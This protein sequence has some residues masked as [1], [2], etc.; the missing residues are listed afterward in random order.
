[1]SR[2][3]VAL[4]VS[5]LCRIPAVVL[6]DEEVTTRRICK[7][8]GSTRSWD[9]DAGITVLNDGFL[10][11]L[12]ADLGPMTLYQGKLWFILGDTWIAGQPWD[13][14]L[15]PYTVDTAPADGITIEGYLNC[16]AFPA[17]ALS[18]RPNYPI[19]NALFTVNGATS[20][21]M[22]AQFMDVYEVDGHDHHIYNS[23][24]A[25]Y[26]GQA[27]LFRPYK[28]NVYRWTG[29]GAPSTHFHFGMASFRVDRDGGY[30]YMVGSPSGRFGGVKLART[31]IG[32]F[33]NPDGTVPWMY[34]LGNDNWSS[35][36]TD[37][38]VIQAAP[39]LIPPKDP[40]WTLAKNYD[41]L[42]WSEQGPLI[43]IG[44]FSVIYNPFLRK[45]LLITGRPCSAAT[46]GGAWYY[47]ADRLTGPWSSERLLMAN[48]TDGGHEWTYYGTYTTDAL[49]SHGGQRMYMVA[50]T[51]EPY[52]IY[53]YEVRFDNCPGVPNPDQT[54]TDD[55]G[56]GDACDNCPAVANPGQTDTDGDGLGDV[57]DNC[58][59]A[60][61]PGQE[62]VDRDG[63]GDACDNCPVTANP[64]Q[65]DA[66][67]DGVGDVCDNCPVTPNP[68][69][70]DTDGDGLG[71]ACDLCNNTPPGGLIDATGCAPADFTHDG[72]VDADDFGILQMCFN[73]PNRPA[74]YPECHR[75]DLDGD[76]DVDLA[77]FAR[78]QA[79]FNGP[80][81]PPKCLG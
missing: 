26:D 57:C 23:W 73:G 39:W 52:G 58:A 7:I 62:D 74:R 53:L 47:S 44:E 48:R 64:G 5:L 51:W 49:L 2:V 68:G 29:Q 36:T 34:Y 8:V 59:A 6:A 55:D 22:F 45:F 67:H 70:T 24:L 28:T 69:Q 1:M 38:S 9:V 41:T 20:A 54:D 56:S 63:L 75:L 32:E 61:N 72:S 19:P 77:D 18:P 35:P 79:C 46:G 81:R 25:K 60:A 65:E 80:N 17:N 11:V 14:F 27:R 42:P 66:D 31:P 3:S 13:R 37:E 21:G 50:S 4:L 43:T 78:F 12:G 76:V 30:V 33:L 10:G 16:N 15:V 40:N 71:D